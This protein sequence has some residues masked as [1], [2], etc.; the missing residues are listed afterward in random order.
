[1]SIVGVIVNVFNGYI[2][3]RKRHEIDF[4]ESFAN[5]LVLLAVFDILYLLNAIG[6]FG[7]PAIWPWYSGTVYPNILPFR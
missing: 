7:L 6:L 3:L 1:M 5:L 4:T 2:L